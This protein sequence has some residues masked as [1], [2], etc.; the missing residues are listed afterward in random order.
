VGKVHDHMIGLSFVA[1]R[2]LGGISLQY[3]NVL[4]PIEKGILP[5]AF[6]CNGILVHG[7]NPG[8]FSGQ[9]QSVGPHPGEHVQDIVSRLDQPGDAQPLRAQPLGEVGPLQVHLVAQAVLLVNG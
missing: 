9:K 4:D 6:H 8:P 1:K 2:Q 7:H 5:Q 3:L